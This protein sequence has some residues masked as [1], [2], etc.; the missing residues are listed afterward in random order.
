MPNTEEEE[1]PLAVLPHSISIS[2]V[3]TSGDEI[4]FTLKTRVNVCDQKKLKLFLANFNESN[5]CTLN[6]QSGRSSKSKFH[7]VFRNFFI[8]VHC[9]SHAIAW[10]WNSHVILLEFHPTS[11][12]GNEI[13]T[14]WLGNEIPTND[15]SELYTIYNP[16]S[17]RVM[18]FPLDNFSGW[19][20]PHH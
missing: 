18:I 15:S 14:K 7:K 17:C 11:L 19:G 9:S 20:L 5:C 10:E 13:P 16:A 3:N 4:K 8:P 1:C 2:S 12:H 6:I